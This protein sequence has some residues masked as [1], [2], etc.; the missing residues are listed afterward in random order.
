MK[1]VR[2]EPPYKVYALAA[3]GRRQ[4]LEAHGLIVEIRPGVEIEIDLAPHPAFAGTLVML[5]PRA[6]RM[7]RAFDEGIIDDFAVTFGASNVL[8]VSV[9]RQIGRASCR[10][11]V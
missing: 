3:N 9:D 11:R 8:H 7:R 5:T 10:E 6:S 1:R 2:V 4:R